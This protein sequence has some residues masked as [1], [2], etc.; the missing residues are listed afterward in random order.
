MVSP[1]RHPRVRLYV[2]PNL[3]IIPGREWYWFWTNWSGNGIDLG[4]TE[5]G[6]MDSS[7]VSPEGTGSRPP[8]VVV[9]W[10]VCKFSDKVP[11]WLLSLLVP[12]STSREEVLGRMDRNFFTSKRHNTDSGNDNIDYMKLGFTTDY[13]YV[14][15]SGAVFAVGHTLA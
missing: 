3:M 10:L 12:T 14:S 7:P 15:F 5:R 2:F 11:G 6:Y 9:F 1:G 8:E 4:D 13:Y